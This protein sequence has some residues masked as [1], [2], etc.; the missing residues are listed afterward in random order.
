MRRK[1]KAKR[2]EGLIFEAAGDA[3]REKS[4]PRCKEWQ[5][6]CQDPLRQEAHEAL[7]KEYEAATKKSNLERSIF[8]RGVFQGKVGERYCYR[9]GVAPLVL[10]QIAP[11][12]PHSLE[13]YG[14]KIDGEI[15]RCGERNIEIAIA[16]NRGEILP[17]IE[18]IFDLA[19]LIDLVDRRIVEID[20]EPER[21]AV[22][23]ASVLF[24]SLEFPV[25][26]RLK[27][28]CDHIRRQDGALREP[29][30]MEAV[31]RMLSDTFCL[32]WGP[33][34]TEKTYTLLGVL[35]E[36]LAN[37][38]RVLFASNT[39]SAI[40]NV[41]EALLPE[42]K[43]PYRELESTRDEGSL[44]RIGRQTDEQV[45]AVFSPEAI[46]EKRSRRIKEQLEGA[47]NRLREY[48]EEKEK[49][50]RRLGEWEQ[51]N[52]LLD[53]WSKLKND[54]SEFPPES[55]LSGQ[56][57]RLKCQYRLY[58]DTMESV[59]TQFPRWLKD[60][61]DVYAQIRKQRGLGTSASAVLR[62]RTVR[63]ERVT[64]D[65]GVLRKRLAWLSGL[66]PNYMPVVIRELSTLCVLFGVGEGPDE[67]GAEAK[68]DAAKAAGV[69]YPSELCGR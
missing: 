57:E 60:I 36:L 22:S 32:I 65:M 4:V 68:Q 53:R 28:M 6:H 55:D 26:H 47:W 42:K 5:Y 13:I 45:S 48:E 10:E 38:K 27:M 23:R 63:L 61:G 25:T 31:R 51:A 39:N 49:V 46:A 52:E 11:D 69:I 9:F 3:P 67:A 59:C 18:V 58:S 43:C 1:T 40:D 21:F 66:P 37:G 56:T 17:H 64:R 7:N 50:E 20:R 24:G 44:V 35:A 54:L 15:I 62:E 29:D 30:Q 41:F 19:I 8:E 14:Q 12:R 33:P 34:G 16:E 2:V